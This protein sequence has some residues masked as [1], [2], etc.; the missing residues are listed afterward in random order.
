LEKPN[1]SITEAA[2][3]IRAKLG[4]FQPEIALTLGS[5]MGII[6]DEVEN[7]VRIPYA[8]IPHYPV[9][10]VKGHAGRLVAGTLNGKKVLVM[11]GRVHFYEGHPVSTL[12]FPVRVF[13]QLG[14]EKLILTNAA[15]AVNQAL[16]VGDLMII[17]DHINFTF[18]NPLI[19]P[20]EEDL[21][22]RFP[23]NARTYSPRLIEV[24]RKTGEKLGIK[25]KEGVYQF[26]TG[27]SYET[28][29]EV[30]MSRM[31]G[32]DAVGMSTFPEALTANHCGM[33]VLGI[34]FIANLAAG[35]SPTQLS[36]AEVMETSEMVRDK[37]ITLIKGIVE[38]IK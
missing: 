5:G 34:S 33:E 15:G 21:G 19:G 38:R 8:D 26:M 35:L 17:T 22:P 3:F 7:P 31:I 14:I 20:N 4:D 13:H 32:A 16:N 10:T 37:V 23:D 6:A 30:Q 1:S 29:A 25:T 9:S 11:Q 28:P 24:A 12:G 18:T 36:H 27:P 2:D